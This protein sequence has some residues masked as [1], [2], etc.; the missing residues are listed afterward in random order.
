MIAKVRPPTVGRAWAERLRARFVDLENQRRAKQA[1]LNELQIVAERE[2]PQQPELLDM[3]PQLA[4][5]LTDAPTPCS[6]ACTKPA[7]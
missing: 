4:L 1:E 2:Q 6:G 5:N 7:A 3:L